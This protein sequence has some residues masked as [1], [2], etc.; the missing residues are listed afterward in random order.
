MTMEA[1]TAPGNGNGAETPSGTQHWLENVIPEDAVW[2]QDGKDVP[3]RE[4]PV[5]REF[6]SP[7]DMARSLLNAR[8]LVGRKTIGLTPLPDNAT[9]EQKKS[10][11]A[12]FRRIAG[13]PDSPENYEITMPEGRDA[14]PHFVDWFKKA[15][16]GL[17]L[18]P[19]QAQGLA[20][21]Y[22]QMV[23]EFLEG[24]PRRH[25][26]QLAAS[27]EELHGL[28]GEELSERCDAAFQGLDRTARTAGL[29]PREAKD[30]HEKI[31]ESPEMMRLFSA[32]GQTFSEDTLAGERGS[33]RPAGE[34]I[35]TEQFFAENVFGGKGA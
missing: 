34:S 24:E 23:E 11:E 10:F 4:H 17:A 9:E 33:F 7:A 13:V 22:E 14:D 5:L 1:S 25:A 3:L 20:Q 26:R 29:D 8:S 2:T 32:V 19:Q 6:Q 12:E 18:S 27:R 28:W 15:A 30:L 21:G 16:H 35:S 31:A